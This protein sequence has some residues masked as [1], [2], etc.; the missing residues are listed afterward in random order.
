[1]AWRWMSKHSGYLFD[2][3]GNPGSVPIAP[4]TANHPV[5]NFN[6]NLESK[7]FVPQR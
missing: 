6:V 2:F 3:V 4:L 7:I 5:K 1:M